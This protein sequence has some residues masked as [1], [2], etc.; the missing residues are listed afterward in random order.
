MKRKKRVFLWRGWAVF[1]LL[2]EL[3]F[4]DSFSLAATVA[5]ATPAVYKVTLK[6]LELS[7]NGGSTWITI[8][9]ADQEMDI[10]SVNAGQVAAGYISNVS[11]PVGTY[12]RMRV[13]ISATFKM[14]GFAYYNTNN[15]T[16]FTTAS[17]DSNVDG[18]VSSIASF[19]GYAEQSITIPGQTQLQS[20]FNLS[21]SPMTIKMGAIQ[22]ATVSF[23]V[24]NTLVLDD[25]SGTVDFYPSQPVVTQTLS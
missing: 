23:D 3:F 9:E 2:A 15:K 19:T 10:A 12:N 6:K 22:K 16:Y 4:V 21:G 1:L 8:K 25:T 5:T 13:T 14:Q 24:T 18:N 20:E 11:I 17:G 7:T